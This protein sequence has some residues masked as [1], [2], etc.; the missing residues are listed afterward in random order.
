MPSPFPGMDPYLEHP[1]VWR[2]IHKG[3]PVEICASLNVSLPDGY[4]AQL[5]ERLEILPESPGTRPGAR[6]DDI[7][8]VRLRGAAGPA[9]AVAE[10]AR[11]TL[12]PPRRV[13]TDEPATLLDVEVYHVEDGKVTQIELL[14]PANKIGGGR[15]DFLRKRR[16][17]LASDL[18]Y[19][20][21]D[22]LRRGRRPCTDADGGP[23]V[24]VPEGTSYVVL[25][26]RAWERGGGPSGYDIDAHFLTLDDEL[27]VVGV[28]LRGG[29]P[30]APLDLQHCFTRMYDSGPFHRAPSRFYDVPT[31]QPLPPA[32]AEWAAA[33]VAAWR[34][35]R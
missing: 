20:E 26:S 1:G 34:D 35:A 9:A 18:S 25:V 3:L 2:H 23:T 17:L 10:P 7:G 6:Y 5:E 33:R 28:P 8:V 29:E 11:T 16:G 27:P 14:S 22:L 12:T 31:V 19:V 4:F 13:K 15:E 30:D 24:W 32:A 21:V